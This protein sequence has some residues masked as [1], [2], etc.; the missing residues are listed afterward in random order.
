MAKPIGEII[1]EIRALAKK[2]KFKDIVKILSDLAHKY[3][4]NPKKLI[5]VLTMRIY[6]NIQL[7]ANQS[8]VSDLNMIKSPY[9]D[10]WK[11]ESYPDVNGDRKGSMCPFSLYLMYSYYP[12][13]VGSTYTALDRLNTLWQHLENE[14]NEGS[15]PR[16]VLV[17]RI[18][19]VG[20]LVADVLISEKRH[21]AG[22]RHQRH[23]WARLRPDRRW[24]KRAE[25]HGNRNGAWIA[26]NRDISC[27]AEVD[28]EESL[29]VSECENMLINN[30]AVSLFYMNRT[31]AAKTTIDSCRHICKNAKLFRGIMLNAA[32]LKGLAVDIDTKYAE[33]DAN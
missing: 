6:Y 9:S 13:L 30:A 28:L 4:K 10:K 15:Q 31:A 32:M 22:S 16:D 21:L 19:R 11:Y 29:L 24:R 1:A 12:Y 17:P 23:A 18:I 2:N 14:L 25:T 5:A 7:N 20:L 8:I 33:D 3:E 27:K 26:A